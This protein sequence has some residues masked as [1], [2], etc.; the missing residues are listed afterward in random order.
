M[1]TATQVG[2]VGGGGSDIPP[3]PYGVGPGGGR[4]AVGVVWGEHSALPLCAGDIAAAQTEGTAACR[5][6]PLPRCAA[7]HEAGGP[8]AASRRLAA[9]P[10]LEVGLLFRL[11]NRVGLCRSRRRRCRQ[12]A[13]QLAAILKADLQYANSQRWRSG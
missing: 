10:P 13:A 3:T 1:S 11:E 6:P 7:A 2:F 8:A 12:I 4:W 5:A 9:S